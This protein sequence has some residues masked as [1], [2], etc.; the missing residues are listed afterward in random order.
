MPLSLSLYLAT[1]YLDCLNDLYTLNPDDSVPT[2][3]EVFT[4][5]YGWTV[6]AV[7]DWQ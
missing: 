6:P 3:D 1:M 5:F 4:R 7:R 2:P